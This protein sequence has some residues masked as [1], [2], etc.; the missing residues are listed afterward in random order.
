MIARA[1][2]HLAEYLGPQTEIW[3]AHRSLIEAMTG[4]S[5]GSVQRREEYCIAQMTDI[6]TLGLASG[7]Y[8]I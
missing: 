6:N 8:V 2:L 5:T 7:R 1:S 3:K 4:I